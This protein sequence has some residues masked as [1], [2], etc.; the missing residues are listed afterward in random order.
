MDVYH[1][2][3]LPAQF[4][5]SAPSMRRSF[6]FLLLLAHLSEL[7]A[8]GA[9]NLSFASSFSNTNNYGLEGDGPGDM[10]DLLIDTNGVGS[11]CHLITYDILPSGGRLRLAGMLGINSPIVDG[12]NV[13][14]PSG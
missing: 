9:I 7:N 14:E 12:D 8:C 6:V 3:H 11:S 2:R 13:F 4:A 5:C 1:Q 10:S